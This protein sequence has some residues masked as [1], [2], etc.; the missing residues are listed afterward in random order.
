MSLRGHLRPL[1]NLREIASGMNGAESLVKIYPIYSK[2]RNGF[3]TAS[4][5]RKESHPAIKENALSGSKHAGRSRNVGQIYTYELFG[6]VVK[7]CVIAD[8]VRIS[9]ACLHCEVMFNGVFY[10]TG[11]QFNK[12][13][14]NIIQD[15]RCNRLLRRVHGRAFE[16][17]QPGVLGE[18]SK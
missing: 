18:L 15:C 17:Y 2:Q 1:L 14:S 12:R 4:A 10:E 11:G 13:S 7:Q 3:V 16:R 9:T 5:I 8:G 6:N